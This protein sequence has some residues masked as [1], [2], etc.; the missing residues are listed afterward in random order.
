[1]HLNVEAIGLIATCFV[2]ASFLVSGEKWIRT[3]NIGGASLFVVYGSLIQSPSVWILNG[4]LFFVHIYKLY[5]LKR[6][7]A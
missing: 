1:M 3:I 5:R 6:K 7:N 4:V 2:L